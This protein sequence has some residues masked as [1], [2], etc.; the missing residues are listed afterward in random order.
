[1]SYNTSGGLSPAVDHHPLPTREPAHADDEPAHE[2][3]HPTVSLVIPTLNEAPNLPWVLRRIPPFIDQVV[4]VDG[5]STDD[6]VKV[7]RAVRP[8]ALIVMEPAK[9]KGA[10][11]RAGFAAST[12]D[13]IVMIDADGSMDPAEIGWYT[14]LL[15]NGFDFVKGSRKLTG[16]SSDD[17]TW[18]R[19]S[20]N[21]ALTGLANLACHRH[22]SDLCYGYIGLR[23]QC[24]PL[25]QLCSDG[26]EIETELAVRAARTGL[27]IAEV[28]S[29][30]FIR[31]SGDS[32]LRTFQDGWRVLRTLVRE[33]TSW[34]PPTAGGIPE[35]VRQVRYNESPVDV[36]RRPD[37]PATLL[38][39]LSTSPLVA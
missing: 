26:F 17:L 20:G 18:L 3:A 15:S 37:D 33:W 19:S 6:T 32:N 36:M 27:R 25:L 24:L 1:M 8:D 9:G 16:G 10:A 13:L 7:A 34:E 28:P 21:R 31:L 12:G 38:G 23:R 5:R 39:S 2:P 35:Y 14:S 29:H 11:I 4:I 30:E 22:F